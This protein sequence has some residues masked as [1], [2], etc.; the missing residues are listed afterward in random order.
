[1]RLSAALKP[2][3]VSDARVIPTTDPRWR[4][5]RD[6]IQENSY[7]TGDFTLSSGRKSDYLFQLRQTTMLPEGQH[8]IGTIIQEYMAKQALRSVGGLELGAVPV[9]V[10]VSMASHYAG[11]PVD[12]FF[13]RKKAKDHG[14]RELVDGYVKD[15]A[16]VLMLDDVTTTGGSIVQAVESL[17]QERRCRISQALSVVDR[18]EG[19]TEELQRSGIALMSICRR[20]D[21]R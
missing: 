17:R 7:L 10:A 2:A 16:E 8:L 21:F 9:V 14:A 6:L 12:A 15:G 5:L 18:E 13:V 3:E 4:R 1:M 19:A 20:S 11:D